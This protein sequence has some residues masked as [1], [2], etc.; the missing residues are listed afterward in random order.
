MVQLELVKL[1]LHC[2]L[3]QEVLKNE[4]KYDTV[5]MVRSAVP[6]REIGFLSGDEEDKTSIVPSTIPEYGKVYV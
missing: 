1:L 2:T 4:T 3:Y 5:Y 6:T